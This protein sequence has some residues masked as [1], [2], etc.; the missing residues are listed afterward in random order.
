MNLNWNA[1]LSE[2]QPQLWREW[3]ARLRWRNLGVT[4]IASAF[5][6]FIL[7]SQ[8][9]ESR[10][11]VVEDPQE[12][13]R[14]IFNTLFW[15]ALFLLM[16]MGSYLLVRDMAREEKRGTLTFLRLTLEPSQKIL[17][18]KLLGVPILVYWAIALAIPL[19]LWVAIGTGLSPFAVFSFYLLGMCACGFAYSYALL[20][21]VSSWGKANPWY[22]VVGVVLEYFLLIVFWR[23]WLVSQ[24]WQDAVL[25]VALAILELASL[26]VLAI[27]CWRTATHRLRHPPEMPRT[28]PKV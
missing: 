6:Q 3:K 21:A 11:G 22:V 2:S 9:Q 4:A 24:N 15:W 13:Y 5:G 17:L 27:L 7:L 26:E 14:S 23:S 19:H 16:V 25:S 20:Y 12:L 28:R 8:F 18:G 10:I 1:K